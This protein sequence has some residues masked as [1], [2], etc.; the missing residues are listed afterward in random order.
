MWSMVS[1]I[2]LKLKIKFQSQVNE[3]KHDEWLYFKSLI[4]KY[5]SGYS[6][7]GRNSSDLDSFEKNFCDIFDQPVVKY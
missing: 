6:N 2:V 7:N 4:W 5:V 1:S 3:K